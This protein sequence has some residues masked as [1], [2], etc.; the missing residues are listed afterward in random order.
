MHPPPGLGRGLTVFNM[1]T[2]GGTFL[3]QA[4][5]GFLIGLFPVAADGSYEL[6]AYRAVFALQAGL[7]LLG[8]LIYSGSRDPLKN[9]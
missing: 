9:L 3:A 2:M 8:S 6:A 7:I 5:S 1:G 4:A